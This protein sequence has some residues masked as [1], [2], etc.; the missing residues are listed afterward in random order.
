MREFAASLYNTKA[1]QHCRTAYMKKAGGLCER[2]LKKGL[3]V[4]AEIVHHKVWL[5]PENIT[6]PNITLRFSNLEAL[7]RQCHEEEHSEANRLAK[8]KPRRYV[9][10]EYG[11]VSVREDTPP[12]EE[13]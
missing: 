3:Y 11:R 5:T 9:V 8:K 2:C 6:D 4:P 12:V 7:C 10:D 13:K 1:W